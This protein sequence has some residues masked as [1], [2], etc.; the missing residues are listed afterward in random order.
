MQYIFAVWEKTV[1]RILRSGKIFLC[2]DFDGTLAPLRPKP[3][4]AKLSRQRLRL[5]RDISRKKNFTVAIISGRSL[6]DLRRKIGLKGIILAGNHGLEIVR[7]GRRF[8]HP[9]AKRFTPLFARIAGALK[10]KIRFFPGAVLEQK[11]LSLSLHYRIVEKHRLRR[12][13]QLFLQAAAP[14]LRKGLK[15]TRGK[16]V[17]ELRPPL[18]WDKGRALLF[19]HQDLK[20]KAG[21][22]IFIGDD[23]TD[24]D[25]FRAVNSLG[26]ISIRVGKSEGSLAK[27][28]LKGTKETEQF[29]TRIKALKADVQD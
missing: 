13:K 9:G 23:L 3:V 16:K 7:S 4:Q 26:G 27:F 15:F 17:W 18:K 20:P 19:L 5:L 8:V 10:K 24:E 28:Y 25:G 6:K 22:T 2:A 14:Y 21:L 11:G 12:L 29:L 1:R